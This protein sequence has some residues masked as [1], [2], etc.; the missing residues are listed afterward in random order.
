MHAHRVSSWWLAIAVLLPPACLAADVEFTAPP[1]RTLQ[2]PSAKGV[3]VCVT[4]DAVT[5]LRQFEA[6]PATPNIPSLQRPR[7]PKNRC[8]G[9]NRSLYGQGM[10]NILT[11]GRQ[12]VEGLVADTLANALSGMGFEVVRDKGQ[13]PA[14]AVHVEILIDRFWGWME[15]PEGMAF[16]DE[17]A[18]DMVGG[19]ETRINL[20]RSGGK[21]VTVTATGDGRCRQGLRYGAA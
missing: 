14:D 21:P 9:R 6:R 11:A 8:I 13:A 5:D 17:T 4:V 7:T 20:S 3:T 18:S 16:L 15:V 1:P 10:D 19:M 2:T 12:T